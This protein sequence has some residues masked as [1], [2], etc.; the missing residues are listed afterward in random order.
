MGRINEGPTDSRPK[1]PLR[2]LRTR[3][4]AETRTSKDPNLFQAGGR[5]GC[6]KTSSAGLGRNPLSLRFDFFPNFAKLGPSRVLA[7]F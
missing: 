3:L 1:R 5:A 2:V 7:L 4:L 6:F